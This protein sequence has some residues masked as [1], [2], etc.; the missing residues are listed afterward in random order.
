M[1]LNLGCGEDRKEGY[2]NVDV[3]GNPDIKHNLNKYPYPFKPNSVDFIFAAHILEHVDNPLKFLKECQKILKKG[4]KMEIRV[5]HVEATG[6][7]FGTMEHKHFFHESAIND[8]TGIN[9]TEFIGHPFKLVKTIVKR[10]RFLFW[11]K[12]EIIW[13][14]EK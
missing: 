9:Q 12:R 2:V 5:P 3:I 14:L 8:V 6:G 11:Q 7:A 1:K 13:I 10:G 4:G